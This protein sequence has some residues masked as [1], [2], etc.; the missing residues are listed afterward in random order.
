MA[1]S[2]S[3]ATYYAKSFCFQSGLPLRICLYE[4]RDLGHPMLKKKYLS[5][6]ETARCAP[7]HSQVCTMA[8]RDMNKQITR[9]KPDG[10]SCFTNGQHRMRSAYLGPEGRKTSRVLKV[11]Y[12]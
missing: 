5:C 1:A 7:W 12:P 4:D 11:P 6:L 3:Y 10:N 9:A 8:A 2:Y